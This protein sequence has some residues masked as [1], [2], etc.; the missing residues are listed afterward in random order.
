[1]SW[2]TA[3]SERLLERGRGREQVCLCKW[4]RVLM[5]EK[6]SMHYTAVDDGRNIN[7]IPRSYWS[8]GKREREKIFIVALQF[9]FLCMCVILVYFQ[10]FFFSH[11]FLPID[12][13]EYLIIIW[14]YRTLILFLLSFL[15]I[16]HSFDHHMILDSCE[17]AVRARSMNYHQ[18]IW[19]F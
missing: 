13:F 17:W 10:T 18:K 14:N 7:F 5:L 16:S 15:G 3:D 2:T 8:S 1:M 6:R 9:P 11:F 4:L 19:N 12:W